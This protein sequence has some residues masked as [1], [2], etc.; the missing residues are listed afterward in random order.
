MRAFWI[1]LLIFWIIIIYN[2]DIIAYLIWWLLVF[3][4]LNLLLFWI[5]TKKKDS[6]DSYVKFG[7]YKIFK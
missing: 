7:D 5:F 1:F 3:I 4:G 2:T 6:Q